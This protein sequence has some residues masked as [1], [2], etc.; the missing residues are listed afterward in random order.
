MAE[1]NVVKTG[2]GTLVF[3][4][5]NSVVRGEFRVVGG[6]LAVSDDIFAAADVAWVPILRA[7]STEGV[8]AA[9][10]DRLRCRIR[11]TENG[12]V[13]VEIRQVKGSV[14]LIL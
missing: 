2:A 1:G 4:T 7:S 9:L 13:A 10:P 3:A 12:L 14:L 6:S 5:T 11:E 8:A